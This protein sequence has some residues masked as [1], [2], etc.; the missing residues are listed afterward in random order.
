MQV[1]HAGTCEKICNGMPQVITAGG[2]VLCVTAL[3]DNL[4]QAQKLAY[5]AL[6]NIQFSGRQYRRDI[7]F[8]AQKNLD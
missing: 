5:A 8:K 3:G 2:R 1:F 6:A 4:K 7:G